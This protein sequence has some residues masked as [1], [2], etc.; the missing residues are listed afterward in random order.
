[1]NDAASPLDCMAV[2]GLSEALTREVCEHYRSRPIAR[3]TVFE[4]LNALALTTAA[5]IYGTDAQQ[6][7][8]RFF[9]LAL[10]RQLE[11]YD[12]EKGIKQ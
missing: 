6:Q 10:A 4:A 1:M 11:E 7:A 8:R 5:V 2:S 12:R 9:E 3:S